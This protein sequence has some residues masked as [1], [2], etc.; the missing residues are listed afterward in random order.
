[1]DILKWLGSSIFVTFSR[2][3]YCL[4]IGAN[5]LLHLAKIHVSTQV[6]VAINFSSMAFNF[7]FTSIFIFHSFNH[8]SI[9]L[10]IFSPFPSSRAIFRISSRCLTSVL[11]IET[12]L[13]SQLILKLLD[14]ACLL[15]LTSNA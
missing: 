12:V 10:S 5:Y 7:I 13:R 2:S 6:I 3:T 15:L 14:T 1:M 8:L 9:Y 11:N 4:I